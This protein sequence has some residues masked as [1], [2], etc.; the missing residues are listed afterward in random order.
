MEQLVTGWAKAGQSLGRFSLI[1]PCLFPR[2]RSLKRGK[3]GEKRVVRPLLSFNRKVFMYRKQDMNK[4][5]QNH[6]QRN[7]G[8]G[9]EWGHN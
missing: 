9:G 7:K 6:N 1:S 4:L 5:I 2:E 3:K 8:D